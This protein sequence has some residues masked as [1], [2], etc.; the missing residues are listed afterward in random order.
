[1]NSS[2]SDSWSDVIIVA[3]LRSIAVR[4]RPASAWTLRSPK[5]KL[6]LLM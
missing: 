5:L 3:D 2:G 6:A 1:M 4:L